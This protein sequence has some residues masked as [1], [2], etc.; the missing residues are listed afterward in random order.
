MK[1]T[2]ILSAVTAS[3]LVG[4]QYAQAIPTPV[5]SPIDSSTDQ[6]NEVQTGFPNGNSAS[7]IDITS[8]V[9]NQ[10]GGV[11]L[12]DYT[13]TAQTSADIAGKLSVYFTTG[14]TGAVIP[15]SVFGG[16]GSTPDNVNTFNISW[17]FNPEQNLT[18]VTVG[19]E[20]DLPPIF[21]SAAALDDN[22][23][24]SNNGADQVGAVLVP[25]APDGGMTMVMLG[26]A[27]CVL[28]AIRRKLA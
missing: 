23:W 20:S 15:G 24:G 12:Y 10:G 17:N 2:L 22:N 21:G 6:L 9:Y 27:F 13:V 4:V 16:T 28:G 19:F 18:G 3:L 5:G 7:Q 11:Y 1:K 14:A 25:N 26:G 8:D